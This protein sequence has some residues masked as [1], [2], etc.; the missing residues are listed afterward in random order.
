MTFVGNWHIYEI[1]KWNEGS[2]NIGIQPY[3]EIDSNNQGEF[4][5]GSVTGGLDGQVVFDAER[6]QRWEFTWE[7]S[8]E[9]DPISGSGWVRIKGPDILEG[10]LRIHQGSRS[11]FLAKRAEKNN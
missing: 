6:K 11:K 9:L 7:G 4:Q 8:N 10:E 1:E 5:F 2:D 3:I